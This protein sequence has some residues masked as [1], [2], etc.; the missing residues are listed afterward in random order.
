MVAYFDNI[1]V[2]E[3]KN[4]FDFEDPTDIAYMGIGDNCGE[5]SFAIVDAADEGL[6]VNTISGANSKVLKMYGHTLDYPQ[7]KISFGKTLPAGTVISLDVAYKDPNGSTGWFGFII[8]GTWHEYENA[9][10]MS[11]GLYWERLEITLE[12]EASYITIGGNYL[13][14]YA[15]ISDKSAMV[16][17]FDNITVVSE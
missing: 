4:S 9:Y 1:F 11:K 7:V 13:G 10:W 2:K 14:N 17:Y 15:A 16:A 5:A 3:P 8:N 6:P 12:A